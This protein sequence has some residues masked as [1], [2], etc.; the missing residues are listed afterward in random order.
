VPPVP[1]VPGSFG[2]GGSGG[3]QSVP[4]L[5]VVATL[6]SLLPPGGDRRIALAERRGRALRLFFFQERPG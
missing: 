1:S 3:S 2:S 6:F 5:V 4:F